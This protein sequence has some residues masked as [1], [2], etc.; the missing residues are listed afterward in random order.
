MTLYGWT[1]QNFQLARD[2]VK[3]QIRP[4]PR[5]GY[6][7]FSSA[8]LITYEA[9]KCKYLKEQLNVM[10]GEMNFLYKNETLA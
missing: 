4:L 10:D 1:L 9:I 6:S 5:Y 7:D 3:G 2:G 8:A